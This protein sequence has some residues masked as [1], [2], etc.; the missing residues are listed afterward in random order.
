ALALISFF[1]NF[2]VIPL[3]GKEFVPE[4][5]QSFVSLRLNTPVGSSL[6]YTNAKVMEVEQALKP[7]SEIELLMTT[8]GTDDG[9]NY[10]RVNLKLREPWA[11][12]RTQKELEMLIRKTLRPIPGIELALG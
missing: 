7:F 1:A 2:V 3:V 8:I 11:R 5:D 9:R 12:A 6:E 10:A 4:T